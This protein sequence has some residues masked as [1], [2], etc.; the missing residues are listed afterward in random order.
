M[1]NPRA[2]AL[3]LTLVMLMGCLIPQV[4]G[5]LWVESNIGL[6]Q[7]LAMGLFVVWYDWVL[8]RSTL[9]ISLYILFTGTVPMNIF[10]NEDE[11][12]E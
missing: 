5:M 3:M 9:N 10:I 1:N 4:L 8:L 2:D 12:E 7:A 11:E 6:G